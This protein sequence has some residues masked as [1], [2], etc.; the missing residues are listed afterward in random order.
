MHKH[1]NFKHRNLIYDIVYISIFSSFIVLCSLISI[2][3]VIPFS[4]QTFA[5]FV[6]SLLLGLKYAVSSIII[7]ILLGIVGLPV[8]SGFNGGISAIAG[9]TGGYI[10]G[11]V[12]IPIAIWFFSRISTKALCESNAYK[13]V[14]MSAGLLFCYSF[15]AVWFSISY[16]LNGNNTSFFTIIKYCILPFIIPDCAKMLLAVFVTKRLS[17]IIRTVNV[18]NKTYEKR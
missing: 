7:Y 6:I 17:K 4:L 5:I 14:M 13:I 9:P 16:L 11:F 15:G 1:I 2:P 12:F 10:I 18:Q 8:F 3:A